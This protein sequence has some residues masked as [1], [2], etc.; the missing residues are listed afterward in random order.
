RRGAKKVEG[1]QAGGAGARERPANR[2]RDGRYA[3]AS[4]EPDRQPAVHRGKRNGQ[5][6]APNQDRDERP[7]QDVGPVDQ[8]TQK[9]KPDRH[10]NE[11]AVEPTDAAR[12]RLRL[13]H[14]VFRASVREATSGG[15]QNSLA[16]RFS[17]RG[18][19]IAR[20]RTFFLRSIVA[21]NIDMAQYA[22]G[23]VRTRDGVFAATE[24]LRSILRWDEFSIFPMFSLRPLSS[25]SGSQR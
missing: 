5:H 21:P 20:S 11:L 18:A 12:L 25:R 7:D 10:L 23:P 4:P 3:A 19:A 1:R 14:R 24:A 13:V 22:G 9:P 2:R 15:E 17:S 6:D 8:E 16:I